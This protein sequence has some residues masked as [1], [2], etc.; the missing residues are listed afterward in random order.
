MV[1]EINAI[2]QGFTTKTVI[3]Q[4]IR[5]ARILTQLTVGNYNTDSL[6]TKITVDM[7][8]SLFNTETN[9][10]FLSRGAQRMSTLVLLFR[11][12]SNHAIDTFQTNTQ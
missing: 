7:H 12:E 11:S 1:T 2:T 6:I 10:K 3:T 5:T 8:T 4:P 9:S